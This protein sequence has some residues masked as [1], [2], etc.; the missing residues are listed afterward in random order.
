MVTLNSDQHYD[1]KEVT[2]GESWL[3]VHINPDHDDDD[4]DDEGIT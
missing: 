4:D 2:T 1:Q 3:P